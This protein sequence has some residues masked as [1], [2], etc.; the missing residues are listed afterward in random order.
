M[1]PSRTRQRFR[2]TDDPREVVLYLSID[3]ARAISDGMQHTTYDSSALFERAEKIGGELEE[4]LD[5]TDDFDGPVVHTPR[6]SMKAEP[7]RDELHYDPTTPYPVS[8]DP[9]R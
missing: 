1:I 5:A 7:S 9:R 8:E 2:Y 6:R 3:E 4:F